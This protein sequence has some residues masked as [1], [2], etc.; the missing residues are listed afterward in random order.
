MNILTH[1]KRI[2]TRTRQWLE[3]SRWLGTT[4]FSS[5]RASSRKGVRF[6]NGRIASSSLYY[7]RALHPNAITNRPLLHWGHRIT[8]D[9]MMYQRCALL[10]TERREISRMEG[11]EMCHFTMHDISGAI[12]SIN[13]RIRTWFESFCHAHPIKHPNSRTNTLQRNQEVK[14]FRLGY[15]F[16]ADYLQN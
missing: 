10:W 9:M 13:P 15:Q 6:K 11:V 7:P 1:E 4:I 2:S 12:L 14:E 16:S 8:K 3:S 5:T